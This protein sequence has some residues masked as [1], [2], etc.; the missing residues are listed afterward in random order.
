MYIV[1]SVVTPWSTGVNVSSP[2]NLGP[3]CLSAFILSPIN[4]A[5]RG[6]RLEGSWR[7]LSTWQQVALQIVLHYRRALSVALAACLSADIPSHENNHDLIYFRTNQKSWLGIALLVLWETMVED[8][9]DPTY[10]SNVIFLKNSK[11]FKVPEN[12]FLSSYRSHGS[13]TACED[14]FA[15]QT[16]VSWLVIRGELAR[17]A[18]RFVQVL[19]DGF[20]CSIRFNGIFN[21]MGILIFAREPQGVFKRAD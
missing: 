5:H 19:D 13:K 1:L 11:G 8:F 21:L 20:I 15:L 7:L 16:S 10:L 14:L 17:I 9:E 2:I 3:V 12:L 6:Q 4:V 18:N